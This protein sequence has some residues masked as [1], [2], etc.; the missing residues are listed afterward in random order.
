MITPVVYTY[1]SAMFGPVVF[2]WPADLILHWARLL[3]LV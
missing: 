3:E 2:A 1:L